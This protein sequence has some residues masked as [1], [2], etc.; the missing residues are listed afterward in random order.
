[1]RHF[2]CK[3]AEFFKYFGLHLDLDLT[4]EKK[5]EMCLD[6]DCFKKQDWILIAKY[7]SPLISDDPLISAM[8]LLVRWF[9]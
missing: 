4:F 1:M 8:K 7:D 6:W 9:T 3:K 2:C 5:I